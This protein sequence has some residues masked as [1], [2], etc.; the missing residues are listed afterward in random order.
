LTVVEAKLLAQRLSNIR[1]KA[2]AELF[3]ASGIRVGELYGLSKNDINLK[4]RTA[5]VLGKGNKHRLANF[6]EYGAFLLEQVIIKLAPGNGP[7]FVSQRKGRLS[8]GGIQAVITK[9]GKAAKL[10][11]KLHP[12]IFRHT[13]ASNLVNKG[14][15]LQVVADELG[16]EKLKTAAIYG[17]VLKPEVL[18]VYR[19]CME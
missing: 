16:H 6:S 11:R 4:D 15:D 9:L 3:D 18:N 14:A 7:V 12:H 17:R 19:R 5:W 13:F 1:D 8:I 10:G 2:I